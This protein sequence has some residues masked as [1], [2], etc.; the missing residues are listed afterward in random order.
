MGVKH[1]LRIVCLKCD[2]QTTPPYT[3]ARTPSP[4]HQP[5]QQAARPP[6]TVPQ[7]VVVLCCVLPAALLL[8]HAHDHGALQHG[9]HMLQVLLQG[10]DGREGGKTDRGEVRR[11]TERGNGVSQCREESQDRQKDRLS[12]GASSSCRFGL[13]AAALLLPACQ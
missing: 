12:E 7:E 4:L 3:F 11:V 6:L 13:S 10:E 5:P 9:H 8:L 1:P 2:P